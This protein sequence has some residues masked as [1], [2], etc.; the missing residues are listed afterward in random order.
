MLKSSLKPF[1]DSCKLPFK[2]ELNRFSGLLLIVISFLKLM[3]FLSLLNP[4]RIQPATRFSVTRFF[5]R[6]NYKYSLGKNN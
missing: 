1:W 3:D 2:E 5:I 6:F 4:P